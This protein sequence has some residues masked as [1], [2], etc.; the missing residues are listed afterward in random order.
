MA[1]VVSSLA[2]PASHKS[3]DGECTAVFVRSPVWNFGPA[4][5]EYAST[6]TVTETVDCGGCQQLVTQ[7]RGFGHGPVRIAFRAECQMLMPHRSDISKPQSLNP[8]PR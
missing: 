6:V 7:M 5:T 1:A 2:V 4:I 3:N 8:Q